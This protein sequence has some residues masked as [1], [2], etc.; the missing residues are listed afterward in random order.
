MKIH[1]HSTR[2]LM[3][4]APFALAVVPVPGF[5]ADVDLNY[6]ESALDAI[7]TLVAQLVPLAI[8]I[9]LL[10]FIWG[11]VQFIVSSGD[12]EARDAGKRRMVWGIIALFVIVSVWGLVGLLNELT[13]IEQGSGFTIPPS[14]L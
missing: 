8:A 3:F 14:G 1:R 12:E 4:S 9:G 11:I 7:A 10:F 2:F 13:G 5:S 6:L